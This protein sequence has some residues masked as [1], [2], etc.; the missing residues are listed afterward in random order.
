MNFTIEKKEIPK[1]TYPWLK[2][3]YIGCLACISPM[4]LISPFWFVILLIPI[5]VSIIWYINY[6]WRQEGAAS[7]PLREN[8]PFISRPNLEIRISE[9]SKKTYR[10]LHNFWDKR[11]DYHEGT[12]LYKAQSNPE[13]PE[14]HNV[15][16]SLFK[17]ELDGG[18]LLQ[19]LS[20]EGG[21]SNF[22]S[23][24]LWLDYETQSVTRLME[25]GP[26]C[27]SA[28]RDNPWLITGYN[29]KGNIELHIKKL[30]Q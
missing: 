10:S 26:Y 30:I 19:K 21:S 29:D 14:I 5:T 2:Y 6:R 17:H 16:I 25:V 11:I 4:F 8:L 27:I 20:S 15:M 9:F 18:V 12:Y 13:I 23:H 24:L 3:L 7:R 22:S 1:P 28:K